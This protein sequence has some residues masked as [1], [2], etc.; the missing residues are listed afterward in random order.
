MKHLVRGLSG[1]AVDKAFIP[2]SH[3]KKG[4]VYKLHRL[5]REVCGTDTVNGHVE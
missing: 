3:F 4:I 5:Q 2:V 1:A